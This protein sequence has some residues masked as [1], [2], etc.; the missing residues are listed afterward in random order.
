MLIMGLDGAGASRARI[1]ASLSSKQVLSLVNP[2]CQISRRGRGTLSSVDILT[3]T[4]ST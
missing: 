3:R 1:W 2:A 4:D